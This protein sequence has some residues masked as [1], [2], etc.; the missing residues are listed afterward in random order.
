MKIL[1]FKLV[2]GEEV[3]ARV[4]GQLD[5]KYLVSKAQVLQFQQVRPGQMALA[6][7]PWILSNPEAS[8]IPIQMSNVITAVPPSEKVEKEYLA[9]TSNIMLME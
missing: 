9:Q 2:S 3:I 6:L 4:N 5:D 1:A 8:D 7:V